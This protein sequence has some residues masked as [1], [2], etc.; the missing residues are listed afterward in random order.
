MTSAATT[1]RAETATTLW[2]QIIF[3]AAPPSAWSATIRARGSPA[4]IATPY[5]NT[6]NIMLE[7]V[8]L[9]ATKAPTVPT[10]G[11]RSGQSWPVTAAMAPARTRGMLGMPASLWPERMNIRTRGTQKERAR[12]AGPSLRPASCAAWSRFLAGILWTAEAERAPIR[13]RNPGR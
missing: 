8:L 1:R 5:W 4:S 7:T 10:M 6:P 11:D 12:A 9:P 2:T 13:K 3:P